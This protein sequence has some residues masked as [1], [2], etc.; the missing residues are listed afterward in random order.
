MNPNLMAQD[1][2]RPKIWNAS[3]CRCNSVCPHLFGTGRHG[4]GDRSAI[5][6]KWCVLVWGADRTG[7]LTVPRKRRPQRLI[8]RYAQS[9][10]CDVTIAN[11]VTVEQLKDWRAEGF[12]VIV[13]EVETGRY[14]TGAILP[15]S[16]DA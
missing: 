12:E 4:G 3:K 5:E 10:L 2:L 9:R 6:E 7:V 8:N 14:V 15:S 1:G 13:R 11:Y 16:F